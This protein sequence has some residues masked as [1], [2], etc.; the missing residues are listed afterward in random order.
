MITERDKQMIYKFL[1]FMTVAILATHA[2]ATQDDF[3][4]ELSE[5]VQLTPR[6]VRP[7]AWQLNLDEQDKRAVLEARSTLVGFLQSFR[8]E[9][10]DPVNYLASALR[11]RFT[12]R[13][14]L[15]RAMGGGPEAYFLKFQVIDFVYRKKAKEVIFYTD[16]TISAEGE[17]HTRPSAFAV[18]EIAGD[19]KIAR[20][21]NDIRS[22]EFEEQR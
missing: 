6:T 11:K 12:S 19:W 3:V 5:P 10:E 9:Q 20:L 17:D 15:Y 7:I 16:F 2:S 22:R 13:E 8:R 21:G 14:Q 4:K 1:A 18:R